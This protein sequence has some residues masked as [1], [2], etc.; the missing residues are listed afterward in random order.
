MKIYNKKGFVWGVFWLVLGA[1]GLVMELFIHP[2]DFLPEMIKGI[3]IDGILVLVGLTGFLRALSAQA[4]REDLIE[5]NDERN[6]LV[7]LKSAAKTNSFMFLF[8]VLAVI[9][10]GI[11]FYGTEEIGWA[12]VCVVALMFATIWFIVSIVMFVYYEKR[13]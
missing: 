9:L 7:H 5:A 8:Y 12:V 10:G 4:T 6:K 11:G 1:C 2:S 3:I 13:V